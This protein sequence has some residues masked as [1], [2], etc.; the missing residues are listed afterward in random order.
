MPYARVTNLRP[1]GSQF[2]V[3]ALVGNGFD[4]QVMHEY[5]Q[6]TTTRYSDF[7]HFMK[8]RNVSP[9]NLILQEMERAVADGKRNWSDV[10]ECVGNLESGGMR[11]TDI[12]DSLY[13]VTK[14]FSDFL[15][16]VVSPDLLS[17]L[18]DDAQ[19][20]RWGH[21]SLSKF[22][23]DIPTLAELKKI[24]FGALKSNYDL[25]NF[26]FVNFNYTSLLDNYIY[27]DS[28]QFDPV[29]HST[30]DT[31]FLFDTDPKELTKKS[32]GDSWNFSS[33]SYVEMQV[34][35]PHGYQDIPR[36]L[37]FGTNGDGDPRSS[38]AKLAKTYWARVEQRYAHLFDDTQLFIVFGCS[39]GATD[40]WWWEHIAKSLASAK[41]RE[42][43]LLLYW[44]NPPMKPKLPENEVLALFCNAANVA[45]DDRAELAKKIIVFSYNDEDDRTWLS[46]RRD[47]SEPEQ[48]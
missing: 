21:N 23:R 6:Q 9:D 46:T 41:V 18:N 31:N 17:S 37:L 34:V 26:Y 20:H 12:R 8:M 43:A 7:Y 1:L 15:N 5:A 13:E 35:H 42:R 10:E 14:C 28:A 44:W 33:S 22:L 47:A 24:P 27:M 48:R 30:V 40:L 3:M 45:E 4:I 32:N 11:I 25:Y 38:G 29:P 16:A 36:S 19:Q 2:N 39:F